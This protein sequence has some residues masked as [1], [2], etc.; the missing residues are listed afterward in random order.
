MKKIAI[1]LLISVVAVVS[2]FSGCAKESETADD[3]FMSPYSHDFGDKTYALIEIEG[4]G[5]ISLELYSDE[6]PISVANFVE[7][8][9][10]GFYNGLIFHRVIDDFMIQGGDPTGTGYGSSDQK[11]IKGEFSENGVTNRISH[12]RGT[13]SMARSQNYNSASSQFFICQAD[14]TYL[15]GQYAAFGC[16]TDGMDVVDKIAAVDVDS[17]NKPLTDVVIK[18]VKIATASSTSSIGNFS[19]D[20]IFCMSQ[21]KNKNYSKQGYPI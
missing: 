16:V 4:Y 10:S 15:D 18:S 1:F 8:A 13:I 14:C 9:N 2:V 7:L 12:V 20:L 19:H 21:D 6:A 17:N 3:D 11:T 5:E